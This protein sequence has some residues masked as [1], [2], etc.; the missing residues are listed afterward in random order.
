MKSSGTHLL[1]R[2]QGLSQD[3]ITGGQFVPFAKILG[4]ILFLGGQKFVHPSADAKR[5]V[6]LDF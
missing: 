4:D 6:F 3:L 2:K 1:V 5:F